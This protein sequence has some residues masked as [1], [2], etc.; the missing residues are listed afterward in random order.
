[1]KTLALR[2]SGLVAALVVASASLTACGSDEDSGPTAQEQVCTAREGVSSAVKAVGDDLKSA[3]LGDAKTSAADIG[4]AFDDLTAAIG[5]L[6]DEEREALQP[7]VD[8]ITSELAGL[9]DVT[10]IAGLETIITTVGSD[11]SAL[12]DDIEADLDCSK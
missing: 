5:N 1:M 12:T 2:S 4:P 8:A 11:I 7:Q 6:K 10:S 3:N 9:G